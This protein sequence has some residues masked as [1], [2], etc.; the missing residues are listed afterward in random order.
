MATGL[1]IISFDFWSSPTSCCQL[2]PI[3][4]YQMKTV[5]AAVELKI[6]MV[7]LKVAAGDLV[8]FSKVVVVVA[9]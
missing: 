4:P 2:K 7:L 6:E 5:A 1:M 8:Q 9:A 3:V